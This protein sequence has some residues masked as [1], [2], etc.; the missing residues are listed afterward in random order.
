MAH[1][2]T[3][4]VAWLAAGA[5]DELSAPARRAIDAEAPTICPVV[6]LEL[7]RLHETGRLTVPAG[8]I[9]IDLERRIGLVRAPTPFPSVC[10]A[11]AEVVWTRDPFDR[12]IVG[13]AAC[14]DAP[15]VTRDRRIR[16]NYPYACW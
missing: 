2:D 12:L 10:A 7:A 8:E 15:L 3:H 5:V 4:V 14:T 6:E 16:D 9:L 11:A 13:T 1:L